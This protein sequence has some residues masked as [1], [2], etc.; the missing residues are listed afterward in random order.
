M[1]E[2]DFKAAACVQYILNRIVISLEDEGIGPARWMPF[3][4]LCL[5]EDIVIFSIC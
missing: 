1:K 4:P 2:A 3:F 5:I